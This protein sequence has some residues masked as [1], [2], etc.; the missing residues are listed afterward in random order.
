[1]KTQY[2]EKPF[3]QKKLNEILS[4]IITAVISIQLLV[5]CFCNKLEG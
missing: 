4:S 1:M 2:K 3:Y 5:G